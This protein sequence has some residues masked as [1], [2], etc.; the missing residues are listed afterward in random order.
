MYQNHPASNAAPCKC[1]DGGLLPYVDAETATAIEQ[2]RIELRALDLVRDR[3]PLRIA[4]ARNLIKLEPPGFVA[5][6]PPKDPAALSDT[7]RAMYSTIPGPSSTIHL[8]GDLVLD[9]VPIHCSA[10]ID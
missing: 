3:P 9:F 8:E 5:L 2:D 7:C 10:V 4:Q 6:A 1:V